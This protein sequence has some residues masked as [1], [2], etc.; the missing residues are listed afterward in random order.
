METITGFFKSA[1][2]FVVATFGVNA[3][4]EEPKYTVIEKIDPQTEIRLYAPRIAAEVT[5]TKTNGQ[6]TEN[7]A[8]GKLAAYIFGDNTTNSK[9]DMTAPV[10]RAGTD[11][12]SKIAMTAPVD[13]RNDA[14][15]MTMRFFMPSE[16]NLGN[17]PQPN[18]K[19]IKIIS[20]PEHLVAVRHYSGF[21]NEE[22]IKEQQA[23]L[24]DSLK[25]TTW[26]QNGISRS[27][28]YNPPWTLPFLRHN[29]ILVDVIR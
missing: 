20:L 19:T 25:S 29:E 10:E 18:D 12:S 11:K 6:R 21:T 27:Y 24:V 15:T 1:V 17:L 16:Y 8:F 14:E 28:F 3:G 9:I 4:I 22:N 23:K 7:A 13:V 2:F 5:V 26:K